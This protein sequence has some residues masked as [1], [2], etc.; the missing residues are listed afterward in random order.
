[1]RSEFKRVLH[2]RPTVAQPSPNRK[3]VSSCQVFCSP[4]P[5]PS[6]NREKVAHRFEKTLTVAQPSPVS[7]PL[8]SPTVARSAKKPGDGGDGK[9]KTLAASGQIG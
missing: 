3:K 7:P 6:P 1:M 5:Q 2:R 8:P 9:K 4:F